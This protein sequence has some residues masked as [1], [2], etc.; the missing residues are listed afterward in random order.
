M[1]LFV[2]HSYIKWNFDAFV[3]R[4]DFVVYVKCS[5]LN[6]FGCSIQ[7]AKKE[8]SGSCIAVMGKVALPLS[9]WLI[10]CANDV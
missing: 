5:S 8:F 6:V 7:F 2:H 1:L 4:K 10:V 3:I 9:T